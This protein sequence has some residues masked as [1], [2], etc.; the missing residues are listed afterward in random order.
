L[1]QKF[2]HRSVA[3]F[4]DESTPETL[5]APDTISRRAKLLMA[6][7]LALILALATYLR[8]SNNA[9]TP[10]WYSDEGTHLDIAQHL[11]QGEIQYMAIRDSTLLF[12]KL[13][14][15]ELLL[16]ALLSPARE[17]IATL[18]FLTGVLG[19]ISVA[20]LYEVVRRTTGNLGLALLAALLLAIYP[21]A[22]I[23]SRFG[24]S[25]NLLAPLLLLTFLGV[26]EYLEAEPGHG[27]AW[28]ALAALLVGLGSVS[29]L[30][31]FALIPPLLLLVVVRQPWD[32][33]WGL[34]LLFL[35]FGIYMAFMLLTTPEAFLFDLQYTASRLSKLSLAEQAAQLADNY[36]VWV[37]QDQ[38]LALALVGLFLLRP[39]R[40]QLLMGLLLGAPLLVLGRSVPMYNLTLYYMIPLLPLISLGMAVFLWH[41]IPYA[42][43]QLGRILRSL[44]P[45]RFRRI[46][47]PQSGEVGYRQTVAVLWSSLTS[48]LAYLG[49]LMLVGT[50]L[51]VGTVKLALG[52]AGH[53]DTIIDPFLLEPQ[54]VRDTAHFVNLQSD[55]EDVVLASPGMAWLLQTNT[56]DF[57][58][59]M[60][61]NGQ[62][63]LH[64][65]A[66]LPP[67]R[68]A[69]N[70]DYRQARFV[71][72]DNL[73]RTW[74]ANNINGVDQILEAVQSW[75]IRFQS[76][77]ITVYCNPDQP[78]C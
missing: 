36:T 27:Q 56:A 65:P 73:W 40:L 41:A 1:T 19:V 53:L 39:L 21:Q 15:F 47:L 58:M 26:W 4:E 3:E 68:F 42:A 48:P 31:M 77:E 63:T 7:D 22:V 72:V 17:N 33:L 16:A 11:A 28:L 23:Y 2:Y 30:W 67:E 32:A 24:F 44:T 62:E 52:M 5:S 54:S 18:R 71:V 6:V 78:D 75:P 8:L 59:T 13:P 66:S 51:V 14:L 12:A 70:P 76:G 49:V 45:K 60:A 9:N 35:P 10:G 46:L 34:P 37:S 64:L 43:L 29:D 74:A 50:P 20:L 57:Q 69:F 61:F 55:S 25:Y 38:W